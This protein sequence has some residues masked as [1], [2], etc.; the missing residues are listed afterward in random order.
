RGFSG[1]YADE[2]E[3]VAEGA[4]LPPWQIAVLNARTE[5]FHRMMQG[6]PSNECTAMFFPGQRVLGQN[7]D[8]M[9]QL[10]P[11][12][13]LM[14]I[15]RDDG[16]RILQLTEPGIIGKIGLN[17]R[18]MGVC[19]NILNGRVDSVAVPI[20]V[21][22][23]AVLDGNDIAE[24]YDRFDRTNHGT[25]SNILMADENGRAIDMEFADAILKTVDYQGQQP[26]HTN[27]YLS[28]LAKTHNSE[29]DILFENSTVRYKRGREL[30]S[31]V[32]S[33][34]GVSELKS[35]LKNRDDK[36]NPI[37]AK[38]KPLMGLQVG[39]VSSVVMDLPHRTIHVTVGNPQE[40]GYQT[41][42]LA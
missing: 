14:E 37:C 42:S 11:L 38:Y 21:L 10:E 13:V 22:L 39:T 28:E 29:K 16:H 36:Q 7:W 34:A 24:V 40:N 4:G 33:E 25:C 32:S 6:R 35:V 27:H 41:F 18:G 3:A 9:E 2:I 26:L 20:H 30:L 15:E 8:W 31:D 19:L 17:S 23:R 12:M 5:I 1:D